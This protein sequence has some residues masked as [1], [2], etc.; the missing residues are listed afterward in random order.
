MKSESITF[1]AVYC[2]GQT[3]NGVPTCKNMDTYGIKIQ[4]YKNQVFKGLA[5]R[6]AVPCQRSVYDGDDQMGQRAE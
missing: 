3:F 5:P 1:E 2:F 6:L 4:A